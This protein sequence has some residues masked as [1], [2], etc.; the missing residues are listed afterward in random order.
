MKEKNLFKEDV[1]RKGSRLATGLRAH[2]HRTFKKRLERVENLKKV[3]PDAA[4]LM[5]F[6]S[7]CVFTEAKNTFINGE[8]VASILLANAFIEHWL[9][10][11]LESKG[12][13][14]ESKKG[15]KQILGFIK[16][17]K[18]LHEYL[19]E[20]INNLRLLRNPFAH[21]KPANYLHGILNK[22][23]SQQQF[24]DEVLEKEALKAIEL[25]YQ[26]AITRF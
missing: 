6:E 21:L 3:M 2:D 13:E 15:L 16:K 18:M 23:S 4:Y 17:N 11:H 5:S 25:M 1:K 8:F 9:Q 12:F 19:V 7:H 26:I 24:P 22:V 10:V 14:V 20:K